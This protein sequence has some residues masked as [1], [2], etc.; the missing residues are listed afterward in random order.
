M[1]EAAALQMI[2]GHLAD[3]LRRNRRIG[4][5]RG[6]LPPARAAGG[7]PVSEAVAPNE[8]LELLQDRATF[9]GVER[10]RVAYVVESAFLVIKTEQ[11]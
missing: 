1:T 3:E 11:E 5:V 9:G 2:E 7:A 6:A 8:W 10:R 4:T